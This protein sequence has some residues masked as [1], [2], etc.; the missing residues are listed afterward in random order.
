MQLGGY[1][2]LTVQDYPG[3]LAAICFTIG[4][5]LR[6]PYCHNAELVLDQSGG[7]AGEAVAFEFLAY[8]EQ[9]RG[10][11]DGVVVTGGE[12]L[13]QADL[14]DFLLQIKAL[15]LAV[16]LDTNG[17]L[18]ERLSCL[19][20]RGLIDYVAL[21]YKHDRA[22]LAATIGMGEPE[23]Q[24][25]VESHYNSWQASLTCLR[26]HRVPYEL[27]TTVVREL[28]TLAALRRMAD[29]IRAAACAP[30]SW[31]L[32]QFVRRGPIM[33]DHLGSQVSLSAYSAAE[34][35]L[36]VRELQQQ[37]PGVQLR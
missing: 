22:G 34:M 19:L 18:P 16:K 5:Q 3:R 27:R 36:I 6:C 25:A 12:P 10:M 26:E 9:R 2:K 21:D 15:G 17:L 4:C 11:L 13:L 14:A 29:A 31:F 28:H 37:T 8:L 30:E 7:F 20:D 32:Q 1:Q 24:A 35:E 23:Q 33:R